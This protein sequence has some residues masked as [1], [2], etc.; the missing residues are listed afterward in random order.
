MGETIGI[1][2][3]LCSVDCT[4]NISLIYT[5]IIKEAKHNG[6]ECVNGTSGQED[7]DGNLCYKPTETSIES[8]A[9]WCSFGV[10]ITVLFVCAWC[11]CWKFGVCKKKNNTNTEPEE[12]SA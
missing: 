3:G 5:N 8:I 10:G 6:T 11:Y 12:K 2:P 1:K 9:L 4:R 7:C